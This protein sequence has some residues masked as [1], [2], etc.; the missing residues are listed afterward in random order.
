MSPELKTHHP[1]E[2]WKKLVHQGD[3]IYESCLVVGIC[4]KTTI[5]FG[6]PMIF[7]ADV[8]DIDCLTC[9]RMLGIEGGLIQPWA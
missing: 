6:R 7:S 2:K 9:M 4:G 1:T 5:D 3:G 8:V